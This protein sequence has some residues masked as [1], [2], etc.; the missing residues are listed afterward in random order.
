MAVEVHMAEGEID[1]ILAFRAYKLM[2]DE[3]GIPGTFS[4][5]KTLTHVL[6]FVQGPGSVVLLAMDGDLL[7]GV[8][9]LTES[10]FWFSECGSNISLRRSYYIR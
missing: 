1:A 5:V 9:T 6:R 4:P 8:L 7:A 3:G 10:G 2:Y